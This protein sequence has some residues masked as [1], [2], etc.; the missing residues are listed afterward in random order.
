MR[1]LSIQ[2]GV[3]LV[4][5]ATQVES[6]A[7]RPARVRQMAP[8]YRIESISQLRPYFY[9][10]PNANYHRYRAATAAES[11][12]RA[13]AAGLYAQGQFNRLSA[14]ARVIHAEAYSREVDNRRLAAQTYFAMRQANREARAAE[15]GPRPT[16]AD[17]ARFA[18]E[19]RPDRLSPSELSPT[20]D[21]SWPML[22]QGDEFA[23]FRADL[24]E[25]F[26]QRAA[27]GGIPAEAQAKATQ[28]AKAMLES[29]K[30]YVR[31]VDPMDY[32]AARRFLE[33][34]ANEIGQPI[35]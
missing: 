1:A 15:R 32:I 10:V 24:E 20:G 9:Y 19:G 25:T 31:E 23:A 8:L 21:L 17:L 26:V 30:T 6:L 7:Q 12:A 22:L 34:L 29:L 33:S 3:V 28:A 14:E 27:I 4:A 35:G 18:A 5:L 11:Y 16:P 13:V 2:V